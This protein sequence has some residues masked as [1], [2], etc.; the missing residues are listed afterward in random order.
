MILFIY[1][2]YV[3]I[4]SP[5]KR[6]S[7]LCSYDFSGFGHHIWNTLY[8]LGRHVKEA[9]L[10]FPATFLAAFL[11]C[12]QVFHTAQ[13]M[14][15]WNTLPRISWQICH[16]SVLKVTQDFY[17][18][19]TKYRIVNKAHPNSTELLQVHQNIY[20]ILSPCQ[21]DLKAAIVILCNLII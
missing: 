6:F 3:E 2:V 7:M 9:S 18:I 21:W 1:L 4:S 12:F 15:I 8:V 13:P 20:L 5:C 10:S 14:A 11:F 16:N 19:C 17:K